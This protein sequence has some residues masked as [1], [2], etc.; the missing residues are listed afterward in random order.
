MMEK[1]KKKE[2]I[3]TRT[4]AD[5]EKGMRGAEGR[6]DIQEEEGRREEVEKKKQRRVVKEEKSAV[7]SILSVSEKQSCWDQQVVSTTLILK[8]A[9]RPRR[10]LRGQRSPHLK[11]CLN[12]NLCNSTHTRAHTHVFFFLFILFQPIIMSFPFQ[13]YNSLALA[14]A[15]LGPEHT[16]ALMQPLRAHLSTSDHQWEGLMIM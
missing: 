7:N 3:I 10:P 2:R 4:D 9:A 14:L 15:L 11:L 5:K 8:Q 13:R 16:W 12:E 6:Q 1:N